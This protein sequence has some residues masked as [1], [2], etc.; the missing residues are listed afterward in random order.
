M[1]TEL[2]SRSE[3]RSLRKLN[4]INYKMMGDGE[5]QNQ[6]VADSK[7]DELGESPDF[8]TQCA[9]GIS[10]GSGTSGSHSIHKIRSSTIS[11]GTKI[12]QKSW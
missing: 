7:S 9:S 11:T 6:Q 5:A 10:T 2:G 1:S 4:R 8:D 3:I 12:R